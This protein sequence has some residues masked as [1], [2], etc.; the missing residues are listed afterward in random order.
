M[1]H[2][3]YEEVLLLWTSLTAALNGCVNN[4][5]NGNICFLY[6]LYLDKR[7]I[8]CT[9]ENNFVIIHYFCLNTKVK[10]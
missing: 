5:Q 8:I 2:D 1:T 9:E 6:F 4:P 3:S 7:F 10:Y